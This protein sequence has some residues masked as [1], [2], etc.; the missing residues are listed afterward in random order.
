MAQAAGQG[1][2]PIFA[3][4]ETKYFPLAVDAGIEFFKDDHGKAAHLIFHRGSRNMKA[5]E[6]YQRRFSGREC[7]RNYRICLTSFHIADNIPL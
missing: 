7:K 1:K 5:P 6:T 3:E 4:S 2:A